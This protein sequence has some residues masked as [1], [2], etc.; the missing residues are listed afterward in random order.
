MAR[1]IVGID[2]GGTK[3]LAVLVDES[4][5][6]VARA[7]A[8]SP[9]T[10][11]QALMNTVQKAVR[12]VVAK[13]GLTLEEVSAIGAGVPGVVGSDGTCIWAPNCPLTGVP[14]AA[15]LAEA[16]GV[17]AAVGNDVNVGTLG[18]KAFGAGAEFDNVFGM[19]VGT[20]IGGGLVID[21]KVV[22]GEHCLGAEVGHIIIDY[23]AALA[24]DEGG[25]E[26]EF[27]ASRLGV[28]R[29]IRA[30]IAAGRTTCVADQLGADGTD[31]I[32]SGLLRSGL[33][34]GDEVV[35]EALTHAARVI[36]LAS[37]TVIDLV[38]PEAMIYG[39]GVIEACG[40]FMMPII[41]E[42][43]KAHVAP[44][45]GRPLRLLTSQLGDDAVARGA[46]AL[47]A[48]LLSRKQKAQA[49]DREYPVVAAV[50]FG[51]VRVDGEERPRDLVVRADGSLKK[52]RK[53]LSRE[54]HGTAHEVSVEEV[55]YVCKGD[56]QL[57]VV[58][59]GYEALVTVSA[60][61]Q[62]WLERKGIALT[63]LPSPQAAEAFNQA[64]GR[65]ALLLHVGC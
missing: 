15:E 35:T 36:G 46:A 44:G 33:E 29:A 17:P 65:K 43:I 8:N 47:A 59:Q 57:L 34:A 31:R 60:E 38:D 3:I 42:T 37:V 16:F 30:A 22:L 39:G 50:E 62:R 54:V 41:E 14:V 9:T 28:E 32:K 11:S 13:A 26:F 64:E 51:A 55:K 52:R 20:G 2:V 56:T 7:K 63:L 5:A 27:V 1:N 23:A 21:G 6:V 49:V 19:F 48:G 24:G 53:E 45:N 25:G 40:D 18:E 12:Q 58:G 10:T 4:G 61:A